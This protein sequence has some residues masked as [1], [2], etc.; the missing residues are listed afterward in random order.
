MKSIKQAFL[1]LLV[2]NLFSCASRVPVRER[3]ETI[4]PYGIEKAI[5]AD[6]LT[7][8]AAGDNL[9]HDPILKAS[10]KDGVYN[11]NS[12]YS[13]IKDYILPGDIAFINQETILGNKT[14]GYSGYPLFGSPQ[15]AGS[16]IMDAG[17]T[18]VNHA[19]NHVMDK[20]EAGILSTID[21]WD[22][23]NSPNGKHY[24]GIYRSEDERLNRR[25]IINANNIKV[26]F[27]AYTFSTNGIPVPKDKP[28]LVSLT[29][30]EKMA[31]E[32]DELRP[33]CDY[34][35]VSM[36]WGEEYRQDIN[37]TQEKL[38]TLLAE[39]SVDLVIGHHPHVLAPLANI[40]RPDGM[41][42][43]VFYSL[44]NFLSAHVR[45]SKEA[46]LG[47]LA[48]V[49]LKK[50][51]GET[52]AEKIGIIPTLTHY[53]AKMSSFSVYPLPEYTEELAA[54]HWK[55]LNDPEMTQAR[56]YKMAQDLFG[57]ALINYNPF[58]QNP[59]MR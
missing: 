54:K 33:L 16:A 51:D 22:S 1:L 44:G 14:L 38:T 53:D 55:R 10:Y 35:V 52:R 57:P 48:Y 4:P 20:G 21:F 42:M 24:L 25:V 46:L 7:I 32:I 45:P 29:E 59:S 43:T 11:F 36:H 8:I 41:N 13:R 40:T 5:Q 12:I 17:F 34:L 2:F 26:G 31:E 15:E 50:T 23:L 27:L 9:I 28:Y 39:H 18:I 58:F 37:Q 49:R 47:A 56:L 30:P 6:Y 19:N 3:E